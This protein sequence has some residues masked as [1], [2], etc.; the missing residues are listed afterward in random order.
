MDVRHSL[1]DLFDQPLEPDMD[2]Q[3]ISLHLRFQV[4]SPKELHQHEAILLVE[5]HTLELDDV[6]MIQRRQHLSF[7]LQRSLLNGVFEGLR[8]QQLHGIFFV[9]RLI[10][11]FPN[12][13]LTARG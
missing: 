5:H 3:Q 6:R 11:D 4:R 10:H 12:L 13:R 8:K 7:E 9:G 1:R 2:P